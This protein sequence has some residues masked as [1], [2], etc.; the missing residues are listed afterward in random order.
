M[1][2]NRIK[3]FNIKEV[4]QAIAYA[5]DIN[6]ISNKIYMG[7]LSVADSPINP[8]IYGYKKVKSYAEKDNE[9][10]KELLAKAGYPNG[11]KMKLMTN[12]YMSGDKMA[13]LAK[14]QLKE[15]GIDVEIIY[16]SLAEMRDKADSAD[17][18]SVF[19]NHTTPTGNAESTINELFATSSFGPAGNRTYYSNS[20]VDSLLDKVHTISDENEKLAIYGK[21]QDIIQDDVPLIPLGTIKASG[22]VAKKTK[23]FNLEEVGYDYLGKGKK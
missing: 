15:V 5:L 12:T 19:Y 3:P 6:E 11:F 1:L 10:A 22:A 2:N 17:Y 18:E 23:N 16:L 8:N 4:R 20:Q 14:Q 13:L 9:R 21:I 7:E